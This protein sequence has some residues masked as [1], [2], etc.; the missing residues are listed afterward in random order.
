M[1]LEGDKLGGG[2]ARAV[3]RVPKALYE[4]VLVQQAWDGGRACVLDRMSGRIEPAAAIS[5]KR[6]LEPGAS[7]LSQWLRSHTQTS[8]AESSLGFGRW[9]E[10]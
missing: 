5:P 3:P 9:T 8:E 7:N 4:L 6:L 2:L 1:S 10:Q